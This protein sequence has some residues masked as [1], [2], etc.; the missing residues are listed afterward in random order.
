MLQ[1]SH[2][3]YGLDTHFLLPVH[4]NEN[5][6]SR[7]Q[8]LMCSILFDLPILNYVWIIYTSCY[9]VSSNSAYIVPVSWSS[10]HASESWLF[11]KERCR[12]GQ[13]LFPGKT[14]GFQ[15]KEATVLNQQ[16]YLTYETVRQHFK[17]CEL[18][19]DILIL[20]LQ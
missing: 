9:D 17:L 15:L 10:Q 13:C 14:N 20:F 4:K 16:I 1:F 6:P 12:I 8:P 7:K 18:C 2:S 19:C 5:F 11:C 3:K